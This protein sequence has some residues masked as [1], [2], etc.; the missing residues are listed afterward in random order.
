MGTIFAAIALLGGMATFLLCI[1]LLSTVNGYLEKAV[2]QKNWAEQTINER[3]WAADS[4]EVQDLR[5]V[6][7]GPESLERDRRKIRAVLVTSVLVTIAA[8]GWLYYSLLAWPKRF[9]R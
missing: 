7:E 9:S 2:E 8:A 4:I 1:S 3:G 6:L 5:I